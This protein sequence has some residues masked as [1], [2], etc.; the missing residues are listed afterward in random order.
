MTSE[1]VREG[2][3]DPSQIKKYQHHGSW[4][5][6]VPTA[7]RYTILLTAEELGMHSADLANGLVSGELNET[8]ATILLAKLQNNEQ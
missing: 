5:I 7:K 3:D 1:L 4:V 8:G 6:G 2:P